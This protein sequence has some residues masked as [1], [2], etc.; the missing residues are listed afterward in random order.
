MKIWEEPVNTWKDVEGSNIR[1][2]E[3]ITVLKDL[4]RIIRIIRKTRFT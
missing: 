3:L 1:G 4:I 2:L